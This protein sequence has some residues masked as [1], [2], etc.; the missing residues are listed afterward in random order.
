MQLALP[1]LGEKFETF[2]SVQTQVESV[3]QGN[4]NLENR[5]SELLEANNN[6]RESFAHLV[7]G[8]TQTQIEKF[9]AL[10]E[11]F[12]TFASV[13]KQVDNL[14][15]GTSNLENRLTQLLEEN[16]QKRKANKNHNIE[17]N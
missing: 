9:Q 14:V 10:S 15:E 3:I 6:F 2:A 7:Q 11:K 1:A 12:E 16:K 4:S 8:N 5:L 17:T 13:Q